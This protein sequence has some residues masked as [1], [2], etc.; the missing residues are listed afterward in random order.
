[1]HI[2]NIKFASLVCFK[3]Y[4]NNSK[5]SRF[6]IGKYYIIDQ[7]CIICVVSVEKWKINEW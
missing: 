2:Q 6:N 4:E 1:M 5:L 3:L 7:L